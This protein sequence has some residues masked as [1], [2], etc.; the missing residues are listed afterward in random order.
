[1]NFSSLEESLMNFIGLFSCLTDGTAGILKRP[2]EHGNRPGKRE[3]EGQFAPVNP[4]NKKT[5]KEENFYGL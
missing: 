1:M 5:T 3:F 4:V 2:A